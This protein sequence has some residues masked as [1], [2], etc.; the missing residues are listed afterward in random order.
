MEIVTDLHMDSTCSD[1][2]YP[3]SIFLY[4]VVNSGLSSLN[5]SDHDTIDNNPIISTFIKNK[6]IDIQ[7]IPAS[8]IDC[9]QN[10][11]FIYTQKHNLLVACGSDFQ[12]MNHKLSEGSFGIDVD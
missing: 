1:G 4:K 2:K 11:D 3:H 10:G 12:G 9:E 6:S 5:L 7:F 8:E